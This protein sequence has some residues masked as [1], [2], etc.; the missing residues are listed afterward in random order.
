M[1]SRLRTVLVTGGSGFIGRNVVARLRA[2]GLQVLVLDVRADPAM[3]S[4]VGVS[5]FLADVRDERAVDA[6][7]E[8]VDGIIHLASVSG[9]FNLPAVVDHNLVGV[10]NVLDAAHRFE[11]PVVLATKANAA[12]LS[13]PESIISQTA[14]R[15]GN[16]YRQELDSVVNIIRTFDNYGPVPVPGPTQRG[17]IAKFVQEAVAGHEI[18]VDAHRCIDAVHVRDVADVLADALW[19]AAEIG[20]LPVPIE[21]GTG[22][23]LPAAEVAEEVAHKVADITGAIATITVEDSEHYLDTKAADPASLELLYPEGK[24]FVTFD[25]GLDETLQRLRAQA[26]LR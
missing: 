12:V 24:E 23:S 26:A 8:N 14:E 1:S 16:M 11:K 2:D 17:I 4:T 13:D 3:T 22:I 21:L 25:V 7:V 9:I 5:V 15:F 18:V 6:A 19:Y 20:N 10:L